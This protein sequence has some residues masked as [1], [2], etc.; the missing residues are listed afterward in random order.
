MKK[1]TYLVLDEEHNALDYL[2]QSLVFLSQIEQNLFHLK[3]FVVAFH[4]AV[5]SF[6]LLAIQGRNQEHIYEVLPDHLS[7]KEKKKEFDP[8]DRKLISFLDAYKY[9]KNSEKM[10]SSPFIATDNHDQCIKELNNKLRNQ[11]IHFKPMLWG[12]EPWYPAVVCQPLL[13]LL[14]FCIKDEHV[15]LNNS[16]KELSIAY[17]ESINLLLAKHAQ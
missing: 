17:L 12:S 6:M 13:N 16:E 7:G 9:L 4:G 2:I 3:W 5:Y 14:R 11:M 1:D 8:F 15:H 10:S